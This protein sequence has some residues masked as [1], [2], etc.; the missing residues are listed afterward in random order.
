MHADLLSF[1]GLTVAWLGLMGLTFGTM[2][3][4]Q[5]EAGSVAE[6]VTRLDETCRDGLRLHQ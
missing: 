2:V 5:V 1:R 4:G 3:A 6:I